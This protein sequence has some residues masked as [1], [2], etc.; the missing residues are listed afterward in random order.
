MKQKRFWD[1]IELYN[2]TM[3]LFE[4]K[5]YIESNVKQMRDWTPEETESLKSLI[6]EKRSLSEIARTLNKKDFAVIMRT[7]FISGFENKNTKGTKP[8]NFYD[9]TASMQEVYTERMQRWSDNDNIL[10]KR[11]YKDGEN[12]YTL[13]K[14]FHRSP[15]G[16]LMHLQEIFSAK[17]MIELFNTAAK[18]VGM[19]KNSVTHIVE[20]VSMSPDEPENVSSFKRNEKMVKN[21]SNTV[22]TTLDMID[23]G[24]SVKEIAKRRKRN[25]T[26]IVGHIKQMIRDG[27]LNVD[28]FVDIETYNIIIEAGNSVGWESLSKIKETLGEDVSYTSILYVVADVNR[29]GIENQ[30]DEKSLISVEWIKQWLRKQGNNNASK[31]IEQML[32]DFKKGTM[33]SSLLLLFIAVISLTSCSGKKNPQCLQETDTVV[34]EEEY[35]L[36]PITEEVYDELKSSQPSEPIAIVHPQE[37]ET[38]IKT[39]EPCKVKITREYQLGYDRGY[40]D[41]EDDAISSN[42]WQGQYDDSNNFKGQKKEDYELGYCEGYEAGYDDNFEGEDD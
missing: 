39:E 22:R 28:D 36:D 19:K 11:M 21:L 12:I 7:R 18:L 4:N 27:I 42:G 3:A 14:Y 33:H 25:P 24:L 5:D 20:E 10:L 8:K 30:E 37:A 31:I 41:G 9:D 13:A 15:K 40:N 35:F 29:L 6:K 17:E 26:T 1:I 2:N 38:T 23:E 32:E 16:V 34:V